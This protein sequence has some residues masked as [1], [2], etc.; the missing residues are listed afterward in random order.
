MPTGRQSPDPEVIAIRTMGYAEQQ[1][2][3]REAPVRLGISLHD[4]MI[5]AAEAVVRECLLCFHDHTQPAIVFAGPGNNGGDAYAA[6]RLLAAYGRQV[7]ICE[8]MPDR[9]RSP[10]AQIER[11]RAIASGVPLA[12]AD[13]DIPA[14][15]LIIDGL[16]G[17]G[18]HLDRPLDD[19]AAKLFC[20]INR[21]VDSGVRVVAID[22]PSGVEADTGRAHPDAVRADATVTFVRPRT[23]LYLYPG[24]SHAGRIVL[25]NLGI[26]ENMACEIL[27]S[28]PPAPEVL[29]HAAVRGWRPPRPAD[30]HKG[31]FGRVL[32]VGG[33]PGMGGAVSL[34]VGAA[35]RSGAGLVHA[36]IPAAVRTGIDVRHPEALVHVTEPFP[37]SADQIS[38]L[39]Y[40]MA[41]IAAGP[42]LSPGSTAAEMIAE[43][44][45]TNVPL[46]LD[47]GALT[48]MAED[49][50]KF[51]PLL[52]ARA[53]N[54]KPLAILTPHPGEY[55]RLCP[56][57]PPSDRIAAARALAERSGCI[58]VLKGAGTVVAS[59]Q[60]QA[61][62]N[63]TGNDGLAKGGS[64]DVLCGL[65]AGLLAQGME[66]WAAACSAVFLHGLAADIAVAGMGRRAMLAG[67]LPM[68]FGEA[69]RQAGWEE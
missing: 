3:D 15:C 5:R 14:G 62:I 1:A 26:P 45:G 41:A 39:V 19:A 22:I 38:A 59:P 63:T 27:A 12:A 48:C 66:P 44:A 43:L 28:S 7:T 30:G 40:G 65:M 9:P 50:G 8:G 46:V 60:G 10:L 18:F 42:G 21:Q 55:A 57:V 54:G 53:A 47:A 68:F 51:F 35:L 69:F 13:M 33:S 36:S 31:T 25:D 34:A 49:P 52:H 11:E 64:G 56:D 37:P 17:A 2:V 24:R 58:V 16:F 61:A 4:L 29:D 23:G 20:I 32:V 67:D 6:A